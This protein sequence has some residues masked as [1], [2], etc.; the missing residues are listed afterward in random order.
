LN[1]SFLSQPFISR[2]PGSE[3][4]FYSGH[5]YAACQRADNIFIPNG[6]L[7]LYAILLKNQLKV[8]VVQIKDGLR[9]ASGKLPLAG[10]LN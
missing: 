6:T 8:F 3:Q 2:I 9:P 1:Q 10:F 5:L 7:L 4:H